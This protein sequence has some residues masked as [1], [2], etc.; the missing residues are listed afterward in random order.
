MQINLT[1][2]QEE[3]LVQIADHEGT[4]AEELV[5][6]KALCILEEDERFRAAVREGIEAADRGELVEHTEVWARIEAI[7]ES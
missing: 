2:E 6:A 4:S 7:L 1:P 5:R 3:R